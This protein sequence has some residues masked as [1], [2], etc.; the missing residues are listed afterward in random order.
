MMQK[1]G[2]EPHSSRQKFKYKT[3]HHRIGYTEG[4]LLGFSYDFPM[5]LALWS[6][7]RYWTEVG[8][9]ITTLLRRG[10]HLWAMVGDSFQNPTKIL[11]QLQQ[12]YSYSTKILIQL[13]QIIYSYST[14]I[15]IQL[16]QKYSFNF[17]NFFIQEIPW[18]YSVIRSLFPLG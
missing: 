18:C 9:C 4:R 2:K 16:Q 7:S 3:S 8:N 13:Q 10:I 11:I 5:I 6:Q 1:L 17:N 14:K 12:I 15:F